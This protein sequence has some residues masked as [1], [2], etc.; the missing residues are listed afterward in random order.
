MVKFFVTSQDCI[1]TMLLTFKI[2]VFKVQKNRIIRRSEA[3]KLRCVNVHRLFN[4][5]PYRRSLVVHRPIKHWDI[6]KGIIRVS[7]TSSRHGILSVGCM[8]C[9]LINHLSPSLLSISLLFHD[10]ISN[11]KANIFKLWETVNDNTEK[12][13][14]IRCWEVYLSWICRNLFYK[15]LLNILLIVMWTLKQSWSIVSLKSYS[16]LNAGYATSL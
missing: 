14:E 9:L 7:L 1:N 15:V 5:T 13:Q 8:L 16:K 10:F 2:S 11:T 12:I 3:R 6:T 4:R